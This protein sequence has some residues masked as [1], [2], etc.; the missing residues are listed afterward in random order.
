MS[1]ATASI[2]LYRTAS[3]WEMVPSPESLAQ[4][5]L[6]CCEGFHVYDDSG[7]IG[8]VSDVVTDENGSVAA[9]VVSRGWF[10]RDLVRVPTHH[11]SA[12]AL[13]TDRVYISSV[14][15]Q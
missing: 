2:R 7:P 4:S 14:D 1:E 5:W 15:D 6:L 12:I 3:G 8:V 13:A 10:G 9:L 11:I